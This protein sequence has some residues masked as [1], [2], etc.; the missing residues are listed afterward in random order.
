MKKEKRTCECSSEL[1]V[2]PCGNGNM[3]IKAAVHDGGIV[4]FQRG[5]A[6]GFF[7][8]TFCPTCGGRIVERKE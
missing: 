7:D 4:I 5:M 1:K 8:C 2:K 3:G 6:L